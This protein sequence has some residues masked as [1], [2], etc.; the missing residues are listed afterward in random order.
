M[1]R[2]PL[3]GIAL[4]K[5]GRLPRGNRP[6]FIYSRLLTRPSCLPATPAFRPAARRWRGSGLRRSCAS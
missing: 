3:Y 2:V 1:R 6:F 4:K 5:N